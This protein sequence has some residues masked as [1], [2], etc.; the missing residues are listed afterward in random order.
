MTAAACTLGKKA[1]DGV[2]DSAVAQAQEVETNLNGSVANAVNKSV[3]SDGVDKSVISG[4]DLAQDDG[5]IGVMYNVHFGSFSINSTALWE[6]AQ[7]IGM[8]DKAK[9]DALVL[10]GGSNMSRTDQVMVKI[11]EE[12]GGRAAS[13]VHF[14]E[15]GIGILR[16]AKKYENYVKISEYDGSETP[17][18]DTKKYLLDQLKRVLAE[19]DTNCEGKVK[20]MRRLFDEEPYSDDDECADFR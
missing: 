7:R 17:W 13:G 8:Q 18:V 6:Y 12:M 5:T 16:V 19:E 20:V 4:G 14:K 15:F 2:S 10:S 3:I 11:I 1:S 9:I